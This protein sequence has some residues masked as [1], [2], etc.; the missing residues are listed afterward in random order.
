VDAVLFTDWD[1]WSSNT[2]LY[3]NIFY[4][5]GEGR[6]GHAVS[7]AKD[8]AHT[9]APGFGESQKN[10]F[11]SNVYFGHIQAPEDAHALTADP[12]F[13]APGRGALG[14]DSLKGYALQADSM[15]RRSGV[16]VPENGGKD[17]LGT[18]LDKCAAIDRGA[19]QSTPCGER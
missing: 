18:K 8:G 1:G 2:A 19:V 5:L 4:A 6:I 9:S 12:E 3:N 13:A 15:A 7:R 10:L 16:L 17:F 11:D 14:R